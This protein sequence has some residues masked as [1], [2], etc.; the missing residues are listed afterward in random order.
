LV[1]Y[2]SRHKRLA[3]LCLPPE[4]TDHDGGSVHGAGQS[5]VT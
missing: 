2:G 1:L 3:P 5:I 4:K